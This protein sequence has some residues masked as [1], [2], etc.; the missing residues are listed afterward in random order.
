MIKIE[1]HL[2]KPCFKNYNFVDTPRFMARSLSNLFNDLAEGIH[3]IKCKHGHDKKKCKTC[4]IKYRDFECWLEYTNVKD[5]LI[6]YRCLWC[7]FLCCIFHY[8]LFRVCF[9][10]YGMCFLIVSNPASPNVWTSSALFARFTL[11]KLCNK[12]P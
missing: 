1:K 5:D 9:I 8:W 2:Q 4:G 11:D 6:K 10:L 7:A 12:F 3:K